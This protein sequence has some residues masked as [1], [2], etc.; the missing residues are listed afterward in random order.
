MSSRNKRTRFFRR[1][2]AYIN[3]LKIICGVAFLY[4]LFMGVDVL[5]LKK[6]HEK[7]LSDEL[8]QGIMSVDAQYKNLSD[9][10]YLALIDKVKPI[11]QSNKNNEEVQKIL[12]SIENNKNISSLIYWSSV[13]WSDI[14]KKGVFYR[15]SRE[16]AEKASY[17][18]MVSTYTG[19]PGVVHI[20]ELYYSHEHND[21]ILPFGMSIRTAENFPAGVA[22]I[23]LSHRALVLWLMQ[24][25][26]IENADIGILDESE[27]VIING[28]RNFLRNAGKVDLRQESHKVYS[29]LKIDPQQNILQANLFSSDENYAAY[30][31]AGIN[32]D[33]KILLKSNNDDVRHAAL[34]RDIYKSWQGNLPTAFITAAIL[35]FLHLY[36]ETVTRALESVIYR[37]I[38]GREKNRM[39]N[40]RFADYFASPIAR[41]SMS[42]RRQERQ[43][44][45]V[46]NI[47]SKLD[48]IENEHQRFVE[49]THAT[50]AESLL[51]VQESIAML[52]YDRSG[53]PEYK[54]SDE[55]AMRYLKRAHDAILYLKNVMIGRY[56]S[57]DN[58]N[59]DESISVSAAAGNFA[60][61]SAKKKSSAKNGKKSDKKKA[62]EKPSNVIQFPLHL[63]R[64]RDI[65]K[66]KK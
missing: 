26:A 3:A 63:R 38:G 52:A 6:A 16:E 48:E 25:S 4:L 11:Y 62:Q 37:G 21:W 58:P 29:L 49:R 18:K 40:R 56:R 51:P 27:R 34:W 10:I 24:K 2:R 31:N 55:D 14:G 28:N 9:H 39:P 30:V 53:D 45:R 65:E 33:N 59:T 57:S 47:S 32:E 43:Q 17:G 54:L 44:R 64:L 22:V 66:N 15:V 41:V 1:Y 50:I 36:I 19:S 23:G 35:L 12:E 13:V 60:Q 46:D 42:I 20:G 8:K 7:H 61:H 5:R